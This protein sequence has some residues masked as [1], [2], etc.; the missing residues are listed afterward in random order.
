MPK[1]VGLIRWLSTEGLQ[2]RV[3][4]RSWR[5]KLIKKQME[6]INLER[7]HWTAS[8]TVPRGKTNVREIWQNPKR[9][10]SE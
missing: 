4:W 9:V 2:D 5:G 8:S 3:G 6:K 10:W 7:A 1:T